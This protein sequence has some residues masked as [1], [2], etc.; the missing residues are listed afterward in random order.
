MLPLYHI[1][2]HAAIWGK[3][4]HYHGAGAYTPMPR[5]IVGCR[6]YNGNIT[7][8]CYHADY[9]HYW[10]YRAYHGRLL[11]IIFHR[12]PREP[13]LIRRHYGYDAAI[14]ADMPLFT[15][16]DADR[17]SHIRR[18]NTDYHHLLFIAHVCHARLRRYWYADILA[19][20][21]RLAYAVAHWYIDDVM[22]PY[23]TQQLLLRRRLFTTILFWGYAPWRSEYVEMR[24]WL[25]PLLPQRNWLFIS[26]F[27]DIA[28]E[29]YMSF[30]LDIAMP[31][32][33][34]LRHYFHYI[35]DY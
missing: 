16:H 20:L 10:G 29:H 14:D 22:P 35:D 26:R 8:I 17:S 18:L 1:T 25:L 24:A 11:C 27:S 23:A 2:R 9:G 19:P 6:H 13:L 5:H 21:P 31:A 30:T 3:I 28:I 12:M 7:L 4:T 32:D 15:P 34:S 33:M